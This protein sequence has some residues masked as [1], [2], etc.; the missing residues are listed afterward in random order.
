MPAVLAKNIAL[1]NTTAVQEYLC[2]HSFFR[3]RLHLGNLQHAA[4]AGY[5]KAVL[6]CFDNSAGCSLTLFICQ[7]AAPNFQALA[8][9]QLREGARRRIKAADKVVHLLRT[10]RPVDMLHAAVKQ[11]CI[12]CLRIILRLSYS[13]T[14]CNII[15]NL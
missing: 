2:C 13:R 14:G 11:G 1:S 15:N 7:T 6:A 12:G 3:L 10:L 8:V 5:K 9:R 4:A